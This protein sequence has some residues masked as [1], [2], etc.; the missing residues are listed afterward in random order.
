MISGGGIGAVSVSADESTLTLAN[1]IMSVKA[2]GISHT[3]ISDT[4]GI[5]GSQLSGTAGIVGGQ[6]ATNTIAENNLIRNAVGHSAVYFDYDGDSFT[7]DSA[8]SSLYTISNGAS[9]TATLDTTTDAML[10]QSGATSGS[11]SSVNSKRKFLYPTTTAN[12]RRVWE[13]RVK[14]IQSNINHTFQIG[15][16]DSASNNQY[17]SVKRETTTTLNKA[18]LET[19]NAGGTTDSAEFTFTSNVWYILQL[20]WTSNSVKA[21]IDGVLIAQNTTNIDTL[22]SWCFFQAYNN[23]QASNTSLYIDWWRVYGD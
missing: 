17:F 8:L 1:S 20:E 5:L 11:S 4:A 7:S 3:E 22:A 10:L 13:G 18:I 19:H 14:F 12:N 23:G 21:F 16:F 6:I 15:L 9:G 2:K